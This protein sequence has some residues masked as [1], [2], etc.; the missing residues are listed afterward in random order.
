MRRAAL[1]VVGSHALDGHFT[2]GRPLFFGA[3]PWC[4]VRTV[5]SNAH[6]DIAW[7]ARKRHCGGCLSRRGETR[8]LAARAPCRAGCDRSTHYDRALH[9]QQASFF[10]CK[11]VVRRESSDLQCAAGICVAREQAP[12]RWLSLE[13]W[14]NTRACCAR[15]P[16]RADCD[17]PTCY[18]RTLHRRKASLLRCKTVVRSANCTLQR[19][20]GI[21]VA[22]AQAP[23]RWLSLGRWRNTRDCRAPAVSRWL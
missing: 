7:H 10:R 19:A 22:R 16:C 8:E 23:L 9:R 5:P 12:L 2:G 4:D 17:R 20:A 14:Q 11:T 1:V 6:P 3:S 18:E 15:A 13:S 21:R